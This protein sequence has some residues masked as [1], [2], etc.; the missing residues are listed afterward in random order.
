MPEVAIIGAGVS[1]LAVCKTLTE[2]GVPVVVYEA[3]GSIGGIWSNTYAS[4]TLQTPRSSYCFS[5][6]PW[7]DDAPMHPSH[8]QVIHYL[9]GYIDHFRLRSKISLSSKVLEMKR[10]TAGDSWLVDG[11]GYAPLVVHNTGKG[12]ETRGG[13]G[14]VACTLLFRRAHWIV[15]RS[16]R[17]FGIP[18]PFF[19]LTRLSELGLPK[20][21]Q[22]PLVALLQRLSPMR[23]V[24]SKLVELYMVRTYP[25]RKH[26][27]VPS[28]SFSQDLAACILPQLPDK[29]FPLIEQGRILLKRSASWHFTPAGMRLENGEELAADV[30]LLCTGYN[31]LAKVKAMLPEPYSALLEEEGESLHLYRGLVHPR[32][33]DVAFLGFHEGLSSMH[34]AEMGARW[35]TALLRGGFSLPS[36]A[37]MDAERAEWRR[38][39]RAQT[40][41]SQ[42]RVSC[43]APL[44]VWHFDAL[45]R[46]MGWPLMR[47]RGLLQ[48]LLLPYG[49]VDY[50][51]PAPP[52][53][54][55]APGPALTP[56]PVVVTLATGAADAAAAKADKEARSVHAHYQEQ[57]T[58]RGA[59]AA[60]ASATASLTAAA[61]MT[62]ATATE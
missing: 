60:L 2:A 19:F 47:K 37:A 33:P 17:V 50:R 57:R 48:N 27:L 54:S 34:V 52:S 24:T 23:W 20:P 62:P 12:T 18:L 41:F 22:H 4:T 49:S 7:P 13:P 9:Q 6:W 44:H 11:G 39:K 1:G 15:P 3:R 16:G 38:Y 45:C 21:G 26:G 46:D 31:G 5:D 29:F 25:L 40:P 59:A 28:H 53:A 58:A 51:A 61:A 35:L 55:P 14:G 42:G 43:I 32:I 10:A 30:V 36:A 8:D 56:V